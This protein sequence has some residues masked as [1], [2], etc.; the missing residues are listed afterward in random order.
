MFI[1]KLIQYGATN[2]ENSLCSPVLQLYLLKH[3]FS[4]VI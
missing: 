2:Y 3:I 4:L 1:I